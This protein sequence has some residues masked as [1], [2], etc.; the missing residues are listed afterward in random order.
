[1]C[2]NPVTDRVHLQKWSMKLESGLCCVV[3]L[4]SYKTKYDQKTKTKTN[5]NKNKNKTTLLFKLHE[6]IWLNG[7]QLAKMKTSIPGMSLPLKL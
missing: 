7:S 6:Y 3:V 2:I 1:M 4:V 5:K